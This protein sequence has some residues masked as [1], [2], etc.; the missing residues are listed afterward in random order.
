M[1][2]AR[3]GIADTLEPSPLTFVFLDGWSVN[4]GRVSGM[5]DAMLRDGFRLL[6][7]QYKG[8][9]EADAE[10]IYREN[11]PIREGNS[12]HV[13]RLVYPMG[14]SLGLL[15]AHPEARC[16][17][18]RMRRLKGRANPALQ[19]LGQLRH[20]F[21]APNR[22]LSL[23]HSSDDL[24]QTYREGS[25]FF[26]HER[27]D[28]ALLAAQKREQSAGVFD[29]VAGHDALGLERLQE[30]GLGELFAKVRLR[31]VDE[32]R[33]RLERVQT[34]AAALGVYRDVWVDAAKPAPR[35]HALLE[36]RAYLRLVLLETEKLNSLLSALDNERPWARESAHFYRNDWHESERVVQSLWI[37]NRPSAYSTWDSVRQLPPSILYDRWES[38]LFRAYLFNFDDLM[39]SP[40]ANLP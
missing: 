22:I 8:L 17:C 28:R 13:A 29:L 38:L 25:V 9:S 24:R 11:H 5:V 37:L 26:S 3:Q 19:A 14:R 39:V 21:L 34:L 10:E 20:A 12:W 16:A 40:E 7:A 27:I 4:T 33:P 36:A 18:E 23:M 2:E 15:L 6:D 32:L 31:L 1:S 30:P 35:Q